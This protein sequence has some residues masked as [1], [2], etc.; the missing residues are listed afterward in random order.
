MS[1]IRLVLDLYVYVRPKKFVFDFSISN[2][3]EE[4]VPIKDVGSLK[5]PCSVSNIF[6]LLVNLIFVETKYDIFWLKLSL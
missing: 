4:T 3:P 6:L 2:A 1:K 5:N